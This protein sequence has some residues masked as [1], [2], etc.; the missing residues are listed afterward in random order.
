M[1]SAWPILPKTRPSGLVM[2]STAQ[3]ELFGLKRTSAVGRCQKSTYCV[4]I[5]P[6]AAS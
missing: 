3:T 4:A 2:P 5:W 1:R 6:F